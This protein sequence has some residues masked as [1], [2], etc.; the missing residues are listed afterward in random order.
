MRV[1]RPLAN[2]L[3][4]E[5][6]DARS[7]ALAFIGGWIDK[8]V[9]LFRWMVCRVTVRVVPRFLNGD[10][11]GFENPGIPEKVRHDDVFRSVDVVLDDFESCLIHLKRGN[12][13]FGI[14]IAAAGD[15]L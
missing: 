13:G 8:L 14:G 12:G 3:R 6:A 4:N 15:F 7:L 9:C 2:S 10:D 1:M 11:I 5:H